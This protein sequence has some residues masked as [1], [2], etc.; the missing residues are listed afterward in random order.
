M[1]DRKKTV[2]LLEAMLI[3][4]EEAVEVMEEDPVEA[5]AFGM[6]GPIDSLPS[7]ESLI[8]K[9]TNLEKRTLL[10]G[11]RD[12]NSSQP[13]LFRRQVLTIEGEKGKNG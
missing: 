5:G 10:P 3:L 2:V 11:N 1:I 8:K 7:E 6:T 9:G 13:S 4:R 12:K